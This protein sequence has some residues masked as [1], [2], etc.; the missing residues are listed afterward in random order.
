MATSRQTSSE[1]WEFTIKR[2]N[3]LPK[4]VSLRFPTEEEGKR[5]CAQAEALLDRGLVPDGFLRRAKQADTLHTAIRAY[6]EKV[7]IKQEDV[8]LLGLWMKECPANL[9]FLNV[10]FHWGNE[11][12]TR[13]KQVRNLAPGTIRKR[14]GALSRYLT[15]HVALGHLV[16]NPLAILPK[17]YAQY[18]PKDRARLQAIGLDSKADEVRNRWLVLQP[19]N[20]GTCIML[21]HTHPWRG[22]GYATDRIASH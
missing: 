6:A 16:A 4:P 12:I 2:K 14:I 7:N 9:S 22:T 19:I 20:N 1:S 17:G 15:W 13:L 5:Y 11:Q 8:E 18:T 3:L 21:S 10:D